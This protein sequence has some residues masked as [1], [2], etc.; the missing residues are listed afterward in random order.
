MRVHA[1]DEDENLEVQMAPLIDCVFLL[2]IFFLIATSMKEEK[3]SVDLELPEA[4]AAKVILSKAPDYLVVTIDKYGDLYLGENAVDIQSLMTAL[5]KEADKPE[6]ERRIV[7]LDGD[8]R[9][10]YG[11]IVEI[12]EMA[13][14][15]GI[16]EV[17]LRTLNQ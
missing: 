12:V 8:K 10:D 6:T 16:R 7:R 11:R 9:T 15:Y 4:E 2:L 1:Q 13:K 3:L 5:E 17:K 14:L